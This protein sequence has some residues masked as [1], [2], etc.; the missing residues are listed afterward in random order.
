MDNLPS[1][2][3]EKPT[4][5]FIF[6]IVPSRQNGYC[7]LLSQRCSTFR[8]FLSFTFFLFLTIFLL[9][10]LLILQQF[11]KV[12]VKFIL[13]MTIV[14]HYR[15]LH[16]PPCLCLRGFHPYYVIYDK[17]CV[18]KKSKVCG[19]NFK[20]RVCIG[21]GRVCMNFSGE[22]MTR[23][24]QDFLTGRSKRRNTLIPRHVAF[25]HS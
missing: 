19:H 9:Y 10:K 17:I 23:R 1:I 21:M 4:N 2:I 25:Q 7:F 22:G 3:Y 8:S 5:L 16:H 11:S 12:S 18:P 14:Y 13:R 20:G 15:F 6:I 24:I